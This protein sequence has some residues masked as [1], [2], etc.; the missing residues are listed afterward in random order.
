VHKEYYKAAKDLES[1]YHL[2]APEE[3][4]VRSNPLLCR[5]GPCRASTR[6]RF[7][8]SSIIGYFGELCRYD[9][10]YPKKAFGMFRS[11][12]RCMRGHAAIFTWSDLILIGLKPQ[13]RYFAVA[14]RLR[15]ARG[16]QLRS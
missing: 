3:R 2:A 7:S 6:A 10:E 15:H 16:W 14:R 9:D 4:L 12:I 1:R 5:S 11:R 13:A 8:G